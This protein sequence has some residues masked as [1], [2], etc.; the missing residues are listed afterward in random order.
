LC[1]L[2]QSHYEIGINATFWRD[3]SAASAAEAETD[4][5]EAWA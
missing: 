2:I 5:I 1:L 3:E 4:P